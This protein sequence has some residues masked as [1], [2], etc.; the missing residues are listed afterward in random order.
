MDVRFDGAHLLVGATG[1]GLGG[2]GVNPSRDTPFDEVDGSGAAYLFSRFADGWR[3]DAYLKATNTGNSHE[4]GDGLAMSG[5]TIAVGAAGEP[6]A[7]EATPDD[8]SADDSGA[9]YVFQ[10]DCEKA[11]DRT[12]ISGCGE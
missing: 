11:A 10:I 6:S 12:L 1:E 2:V 9:V 4:F 5:D 7:D 8:N 3:L